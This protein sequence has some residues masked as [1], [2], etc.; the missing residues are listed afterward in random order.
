M[1]YE[2]DREILSH[3]A[4]RLAEKFAGVFGMETIERLLHESYDLL[5]ATSRIS[6]YLPLLTERFAL[7]LHQVD[8]V[9]HKQDAVA[10]G[11]SAE[12][13][14]PDQARHSEGLLRDD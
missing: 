5:A 13:N 6:T 2:H 8:V 11:D 7:V 10:D 14:E 3:S 9:G 1:T 4:A 12:R